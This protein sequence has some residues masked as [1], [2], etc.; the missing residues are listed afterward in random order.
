M[1]LPRVAS[2]SQSGDSYQ[3]L[4]ADLQRNI[5]Q[6]ATAIDQLLIKYRKSP[7]DLAARSRRAYQWLIHLD[8]PANLDT[9]LDALQRI[10][11]FLPAVKRH[12]KYKEFRVDFDFYHLGSLYKIQT[13]PSLLQISTQESFCYAP[14]SVLIALLEIAL[15]NHSRN[16]QQQIRDFTFSQSYQSAREKLEYLGIPKGSLAAGAIHDLVTSFQRVNQAYFGNQMAEPH[17][18]WNSRLTIRKFGHFQWDTDTVMVSRTLDQP[19]VPEFVVDY[20]MYHELL[21]KKL[22][23]RLVNSRRMVHTGL[24]RKQ[25]ASYARLEEA[26]NF[27]NR[28]SRTKK[29]T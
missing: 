4:T 12:P 25:E 21:H 7:V 26:Q 24:F 2:A 20:V 19:Q 3:A 27:L 8:H 5:H 28:I 29:L 14:D 22:G 11:L 18:V 15:G 17:L 16:I 6:A 13:R 10:N 1:S 23:T 9:H